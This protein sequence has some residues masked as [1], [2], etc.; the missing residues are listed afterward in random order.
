MEYKYANTTYCHYPQHK[1]C[2]LLFCSNLTVALR[3][4]V[5]HFNWDKLSHCVRRNGLNA[6]LWCISG[7]TQVMTGP[8]SSW[9]HHLTL[10]N[11]GL[12]APVNRSLMLAPLSDPRSPPGWPRVAWHQMM[13]RLLGPVSQCL[14]LWCLMAQQTRMDEW[15]T[16]AP[17]GVSL[18][19]FVM[20]ALGGI[21][22]W[23][24]PAPAIY[25]QLVKS[26]TN[27][28]YHFFHFLQW[29]L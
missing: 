15:D 3:G 22:K 1:I 17:P 13:T 2:R 19:Y 29:K 9:Y 11:T 26:L 5:N 24:V 18:W 27:I 20:T 4:S 10:S 16:E 12:L 14:I 6:S 28:L 8:G 7:H 23:L 25:C 21:N